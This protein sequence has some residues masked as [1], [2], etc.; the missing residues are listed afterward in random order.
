M[1]HTWVTMEDKLGRIRTAPIGFSWWSL[2]CALFFG[3]FIPPL[4]RGQWAVSIVTLFLTFISAG[5]YG[6]IFPFFDYILYRSFLFNNGYR[7]VSVR[8]KM[9]Q[10]EVEE[11]TGWSFP[12]DTD[13]STDSH[14]QKAHDQSFAVWCNGQRPSGNRK[15]KC[16]SQLFRCRK[17]GSSGC[18]NGN[19][20]PCTNAAFKSGRCMSCGNISRDPL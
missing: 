6:L 1:A 5:V 13:V 14:L 20:R 11:T 15:T 16:S 2:L 3:S 7:P 12:S 8:G 19:E 18:L 4:L 17:C 9:T 10:D